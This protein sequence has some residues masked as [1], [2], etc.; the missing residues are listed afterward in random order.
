VEASVAP[1]PKD[2]SITQIV[3]YLKARKKTVGAWVFAVFVSITVTL[4][5][6]GDTYSGFF[7]DAVW[8]W[9]AAGLV[10][11]NIAATV[12]IVLLLRALLQ[13][14]RFWLFVAVVAASIQVLVNSEYQTGLV[15]ADAATQ[16]EE[17]KTFSVGDFYNPLADRLNRS[18][19]TKVRI[20]QREH[21]RPLIAAYPAPD[22]AKNLL[23][24]FLDELDASTY[25][26]DK[27]PA[28]EEKLQKIV[29]NADRKVEQKV[30][31]LGLETY[32]VFSKEQIAD[33]VK[34]ATPS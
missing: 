32:R 10:V 8:N 9:T 31:S 23:A 27:R 13:P 20:A 19:D 18:I 24:V 7:S 25:P 15:G 26:A 4:L 11:T 5:R 12:I 14:Q 2:S 6:L 16:V 22:G 17:L 33:F 21:L 34:L 1:T 29:D 3:G 30:R 28:L